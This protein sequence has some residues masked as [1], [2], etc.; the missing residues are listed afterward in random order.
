MKEAR[1]RRICTECFHLCK[2][3]KHAKLSRL[4]RDVYIDVKTVKKI[5]GMIATQKD[6]RSGYL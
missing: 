2:V 5:K 4:F 1:H 3:Q 6:Q